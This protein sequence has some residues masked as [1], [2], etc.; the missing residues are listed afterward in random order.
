MPSK[1]LPR[2]FN[3]SPIAISVFAASLLAASSCLAEEAPDLSAHASTLHGTL[4]LEEAVQEARQH[5]PDVLGARAAADQFRWKKYEALGGGF[6]PRLDIKGNYYTNKKFEYLN[7]DFEGNPVVFPSIY[8]TTSTSLDLTIPIFD[9]FANIHRLQSAALEQSAAE[10]ELSRTEFETDQ[11]V[12][13]AFYQAL[14]AS[15]SDDVAEENVKTFRDHL[16]QTSIEKQGGAATNYDVLRVEVQL[17]EAES[18]LID[19]RDNVV[20]TRRKLTELLGLEQDDRKIEGVLPTPDAAR[21]ASVNFDPS[22]AQARTDLQA[23]EQRAE[24]SDR[25]RGAQSVWWVP[26][27]AFGADYTWYN[28]LTNSISNSDDFRSAYNVGLFV[29]WNLFDGG[30]SLARAK[31]ASYAQVQ[32]DKAAEKARL[33]L[34]YDFDYWKRRYL[35]N[36]SRF[37]AKQLDLQRSEESVRLAREEQRAGTRTSTEVLDAELDLYRARVGVVNAQSNAAEA[38][39]KLELAVGRRIQ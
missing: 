38:Q 16:K 17:N 31:E 34:P 23:L 14:A 19:A 18:D 22:V 37:K 4:T 32:A 30:V 36:S 39:I 25:N 9:G 7:I 5:S 3:P 21:V 10:N 6:F 24:A 20:L 2:T 29:R 15:L 8:P 12:R 1:Q 28:N 35:S 27:L 26:Q 33:A 13:L 11:Q